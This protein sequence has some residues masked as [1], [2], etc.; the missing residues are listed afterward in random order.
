MPRFNANNSRGGF[1]GTSSLPAIVE[2][3]KLFED[4]GWNSS[5]SHPTSSDDEYDDDDTYDSGDG[6]DCDNDVPTS[7]CSGEGDCNKQ[8]K[9]GPQSQGLSWPHNVVGKSASVAIRIRPPSVSCNNNQSCTNDLEIL[10]SDSDSDSSDDEDEEDIQLNEFQSLVS[11]FG[12]EMMSN[13]ANKCSR[14]KSDDSRAASV[15]MPIMTFDETCSNADVYDGVINDVVREALIGRNGLILVHGHSH[16]SGKTFTMQG[17]TAVSPDN[18]NVVQENRKSVEEGV[19]HLAVKDIFA[20][21][22]EAEDDDLGD[23]R[24]YIV[25]VSYVEIINND[26]EIMRDLLD[27]EDMSSNGSYSNKLSLEDDKMD[28]D[29]VNIMDVIEYVVTDYSMLLEVYDAGES[30]RSKESTTGGDGRSMNSSKSHTIFRV[31][32]ESRDK[33][34]IKCIQSDKAPITEASIFKSEKCPVII[35]TLTFVDLSVTKGTNGF[36]HDSVL[37]LST[38]IKQLCGGSV[39]SLSPP[40]QLPLQGLGK[41]APEKSIKPGR[42]KVVGEKKDEVF[43]SQINFRA[44]KLTHLLKPYLSGNANM[45]FIC[46]V[47]PNE[48]RLE[49]RSTLQF[50]SRVK[51]IDSFVKVNFCNDSNSLFNCPEEYDMMKGEAEVNLEDSIDEDSDGSDYKRTLRDNTKHVKSSSQ[52]EHDKV[53]EDNETT[54]MHFGNLEK[55]IN[56]YKL[57]GIDEA[58]ARELSELEVSV[59]EARSSA[60]AADARLK[61]FRAA[62]GV[63]PNNNLNYDEE[64]DEYLQRNVGDCA[65]TVSLSSMTTTDD[66]DKLREAL[67]SKTDQVRLLRT[68]LDLAERHLRTTHDELHDIKRVL[69]LRES[70]SITSLLDIPSV[71][72]TTPPALRGK[73]M[74]KTPSDRNFGPDFSNKN[75][76]MELLGTLEALKSPPHSDSISKTDG[77]ESTEDGVTEMMRELKSVNEGLL[78]QVNKQA[79]EKIDDEGDATAA[80]TMRKSI[81]ELNRMKDASLTLINTLLSEKKVAQDEIEELSAHNQRLMERCEKVSEAKDLSESQVLKLSEEKK[82]IETEVEQLEAVKKAAFAKLESYSLKKAK[83]VRKRVFRKKEKLKKDKKEKAVQDVSNFHDTK[84]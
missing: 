77:D 14:R 34:D 35:S 63:K 25:R 80:H 76:G 9:R 37:N 53:T 10:S 11:K 52:N 5:S 56:N 8:S 24:E 65:T 71:D 45:S 78:A 4:G 33:K 66:V 27:D 44:S 68:K 60:M 36:F 81:D 19:L 82:T 28:E 12:K 29:I 31:I 17:G 54:E 75:F 15:N 47:N 13:D 39:A 49:T 74:K 40:L 6:D 58:T 48:S 32:I 2:N 72:P 1:R 7:S 51:L 67:T 73:E 20:L 59:V 16:G 41:S 61:S 46:C 26:D 84:L 70:S 21:I 62:K 18:N 79:S 22:K 30:N 55:W 38:V 83:K 69:S 23:K 64:W 50:A 3:E 42:E 43:P 57:D